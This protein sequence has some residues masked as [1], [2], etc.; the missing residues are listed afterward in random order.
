MPGG[1]RPIDNINKSPVP[2]GNDSNLLTKIPGMDEDSSSSPQRPSSVLPMLP[3][4]MMEGGGKKS[5]QVVKNL[6]ENYGFEMVMQFNEYHQRRKML[7]AEER[8]KKGEDGQDVIDGNKDDN[9]DKSEKAPSK[10]LVQQFV[11]MVDANQEKRK[12]EQTKDVEKDKKAEKE[13]SASDK[14]NSLTEAR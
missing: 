4:M 6:L 9:K 8:R 11:N 1:V 10:E 12:E 14:H 2:F 5:P 13:K 3:G 7:D